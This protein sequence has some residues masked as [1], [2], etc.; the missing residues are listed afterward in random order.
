MG[1]AFWNPSRHSHSLF[2]AG[3]ACSSPYNTNDTIILGFVLFQESRKR[4][5]VDGPEKLTGVRRHMMPIRRLSLTDFKTAIPRGARCNRQDYGEYVRGV[6]SR[7]Y[8]ETSS[9]DGKHT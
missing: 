6:F 9:Q 8:Y 4:V 2:T 3:H 5:V 7:T 1:Y